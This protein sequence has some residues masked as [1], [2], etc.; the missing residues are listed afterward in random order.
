MKQRERI[1]D[2]VLAESR[3]M[4]ERQLKEI[5]QS[6]D[7]Q[8]PDPYENALIEE[9]VNRIMA[10]KPANAQKLRMAES[11]A[12]R[13]LRGRQLRD[14]GDILDQK[15]TFQQYLLQ[16]WKPQFESMVRDLQ[17]RGVIYD[18]GGNVLPLSQVM[19]NFWK[20]WFGIE[21]QFAGK[22][23]KTA[24]EWRAVQDIYGAQPVEPSALS[25]AL[26]SLR[27]IKPENYAKWCIFI[28]QK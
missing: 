12:N 22:L 15:E 2:Q 3:G 26:E 27:Q 25:A 6:A 19:G 23:P 17:K 11:R 1:R 21:D 4:T 14:F 7:Y 20:E 13:E 16:R 24:E 18:E 8:P 5:R 9:R 28:S 10:G